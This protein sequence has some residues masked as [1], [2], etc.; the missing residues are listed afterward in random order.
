MCDEHLPAGTRARA[1]TGLETL[2]V[3]AATATTTAEGAASP[4]G[5][6]KGDS[7]KGFEGADNDET[8]SGGGGLDPAAIAEEAARLVKESD[9]VSVKSGDSFKGFE[10]SD[11]ADATAADAA[12]SPT[13][14]RADS[15]SGFEG[16]DVP[17]DEVSAELDPAAV[18]AEAAQLVKEQDAAE[19]AAAK[20][21]ATEEKAA[22][23]KAAEDEKA[24]L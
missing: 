17:S 9:Q 13:M 4:K 24:N 11:Q 18:A 23:K 21:K 2:A 22:A 3:A 16:A 8:Q 5:I 15:F 14:D 10:G 1:A 20:Q 6:A 12:T 7:F 19:K